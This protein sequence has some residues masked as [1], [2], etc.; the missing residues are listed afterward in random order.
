MSSLLLFVGVWEDWF[1][2]ACRQN[3][4]TLDVQDNRGNLAPTQTLQRNRSH[5]SVPKHTLRKHRITHKRVGPDRKRIRVP[6]TRKDAFF[7]E[8]PFRTRRQLRSVLGEND[9]P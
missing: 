5:K 7:M 6:A 1:D 8:R 3:P 9:L 4:I 2:L